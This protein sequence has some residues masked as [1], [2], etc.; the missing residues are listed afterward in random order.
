[1][2]LTKMGLMFVL[3]RD[4]GQP[5]FPVQEVPVPRST[6][7]GEEAWPTQ[8]VPLKPPPLVRQSLTEADLTNI[9]PEAHEYALQEFRKYGRDRSTR[10]P[11]CRAR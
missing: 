3:D 2:Q 1:M 6:V 11:A 10:R 7:P 5:M 9:T 4:T 8:P